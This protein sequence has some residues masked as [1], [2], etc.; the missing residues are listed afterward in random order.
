[1]YNIIDTIFYYFFVFSPG[2]R[3]GLGHIKRCPQAVGV[4]AEAERL[5]LG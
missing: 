3:D 2:M 4:A 1:M 5:S